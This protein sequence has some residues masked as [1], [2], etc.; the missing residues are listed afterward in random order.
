MAPESRPRPVNSASY[1]DTWRVFKTV[2][3][4]TLGKGVIKRRPLVEAAA[5]HHGLDTKA[6]RL[7]QE[8]RD[9]YGSGPLLL[10]LLLRYQV[11]ILNPKDI[12]QVLDETPVPF[13]AASREKKSALAH[14]EPGN[15]LISDP[16]RR[17]Q[18]RP[19]HEKALATNERVHPFADR[20][21]KVID[22]ELDSLLGNA[23][24]DGE[25]DMDW[26]Q[27]SETWFRVVR[28]ITLGEMSRVTTTD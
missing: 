3:A 23:D 21:K 28:R 5:Q 8:L 20:F 9:K 27:F 17:N 19:V 24:G 4:P 10:H 6:V 15:I 14:F 7:L 12:S 25:M 1:Y 2:I 22:E 18:L 16:E 26:N 11:I 13:S